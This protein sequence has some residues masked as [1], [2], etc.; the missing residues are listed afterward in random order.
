MSS[1]EAEGEAPD[2]FG[3]SMAPSPI[4]R[5]SESIMGPGAENDAPSAVSSSPLAV[6][7]DDDEAPA[8]S[9]PPE[10]AQPSIPPAQLY[11]IDRRTQTLPTQTIVLAGAGVFVVLVLLTLLLFR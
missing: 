4:D 9:L 5:A 7:G 1:D 10:P 11:A 2:I 6:A 8:A 3:P